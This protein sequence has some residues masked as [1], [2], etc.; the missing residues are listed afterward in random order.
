MVQLL[1]KWYIKIP[2]RNIVTGAKFPFLSPVHMLYWRNTC[3]WGS[4]TIPSISKQIMGT[5]LTITLRVLSIYYIYLLV[6]HA[7]VQ[8]QEQLSSPQR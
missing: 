4:A 5:K 6:P 3:T 8:F 7:L 1:N 2:Y